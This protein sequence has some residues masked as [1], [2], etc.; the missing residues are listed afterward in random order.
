MGGLP[1]GGSTIGPV[2]LHQRTALLYAVRKFV[3]GITRD[4]WLRLITGSGPRN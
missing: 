2:G 3:A 1:G 4:R